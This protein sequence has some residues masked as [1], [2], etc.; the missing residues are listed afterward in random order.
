[1]PELQL[2]STGKMNNK[3][4]IIIVSC[5]RAARHIIINV[6]PGDAGRMMRLF[7]RKYK[8]NCLTAVVCNGCGKKLV[9]NNGIVREGVTHITVEWDYFS[10]KDGE[11]HGFDLCESCY[12]AMTSH[13]VHPVNI[14]K[15]TELI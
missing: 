7:M 15:K 13:F 10:E 11:V 9:V 12:D 1:M 14:A 4:F 3:L 8:G 2:I 5:W 6:H